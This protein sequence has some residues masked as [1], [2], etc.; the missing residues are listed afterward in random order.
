MLL[1]EA[2]S[3]FTPEYRPVGGVY[4]RLLYAIF[5]LQR[6]PFRII[7]FSLLLAN[8]GLAYVWIKRLSSSRVAGF[9]GAIVVSYHAALTDLY[10]NDGTIYDVLCCGF[11]LLILIN[12]TRTRRT[13]A[14]DGTHLLYLAALFGAALGS[15]EMAMTLPALLALYETLLG[16]GNASGIDRARPVILLAI[17]AAACMTIKIFIPNQ[18]SSNYLY[19]PHLSLRFI[20]ANYLRYHQ[21]LLFENGMTG[22]QLTLFLLS[23][24]GIAV[25]MKN[26]LMLFGLLFSLVALFPVTVIYTRGGFVWYIPLLGYGLYV[27]TL[28]STAVRATVTAFRRSVS[29]SVIPGVACGALLIASYF[30]QEAHTAQL[31]DLGLQN[32]QRA[33]RL[34]LTSAQKVAPTLPRA[35]R[36]LLENDPFPSVGWETLFVLRLGYRDPNLWVDRVATE[37]ATA[38][39]D[40][41]AMKLYWNGSGYTGQLRESRSAHI[42]P[43]EVTP[44]IVRRGAAVSLRFPT[45][46]EGCPIDVAYRMPDDELARA[47][48]WRTW[49]K[50]DPLGRG[51][52]HIDQDIERGHVVIDQIRACD[53]TWTSA[54]GSFSIWP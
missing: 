50:L 46:F 52:A 44:E 6:V 18:M 28:I 36:V 10:Y 37:D 7:F 31:A 16:P 45:G 4:Y 5:G 25:A 26:R 32:Q 43:I 8:L 27:G 29:N 47:G 40:L 39:P 17:M 21:M 51:T 53:R 33:L 14:L 35:S 34:L 11:I 15:K 38:D 2:A 48:V 54:Q 41:Y 1:V 9:V 30:I 23:A 49:S 12:Y 20:S 19:S 42:I 13:G 24:G 3:V 22:F